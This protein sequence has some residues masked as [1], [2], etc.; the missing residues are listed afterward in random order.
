MIDRIGT[1]MTEAPERVF[2]W[3]VAIHM[4]VW[5]VVPWRLHPTIPMD[6]IEGFAWS[7]TWEL[8]YYKQPPV[9]TWVQGFW[10]DLTGGSSLAFYFLSQMFVAVAFWAV[11][12]LAR[13]ILPPARALL[14]VL[15]LEGIFY[16]NFESTDFNHNTAHLT[17]WPVIIL[18]FHRALM[19]RTMGTWVLL[20]VVTGLGL[21]SKYSIVFLFIP[22][23]V[24]LLIDRQ[25]RTVWRTPGPYVTATIMA[26]MAAPHF[27]WVIESGYQTFGYGYSRAR[28][29]TDWWVRLYY[30]VRFIFGQSLVLA[31]VAVMAA[32]LVW[33]RALPSLKPSQW[34]FDQR[35][36]AVL[37]AG[38]FLTYLATSAVLG[39]RI[40]T[41]WVMPIWSL[42]GIIVV[43]FLAAS[44]D[45]ARLRRFVRAWAGFFVLAVA[46]YT[47][48]LTVGPFVSG[49]PSRGYFPSA[50]LAQTVTSAWRKRFDTR[51][52]FVTGKTW[53]A[54]TLALAS[55]DRPL[56]FIEARPEISPA[57][58]MDAYRRAGSAFVW[59]ARKF[60]DAIP[61]G[62]AKQFPGLE[63]QTPLMLPWNRPGLIP[64]VS[65]GWPA[66]LPP[67]RVGWAV[68]PP[69]EN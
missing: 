3:F 69:G 7:R 22:M 14:A 62:W 46:V 2:R 37:G 38:P 56:V 10:F 9:P 59:D 60:G 21:L 45:V 25:S 51:L 31:P 53:M 65:W 64:P 8:G 49:K 36:V 44:P 18:V 42:T 50:A 11:W 55:E 33:R 26:G 48:M 17:L 54:A 23:L 32:I 13:D 16:F 47:V 41:I 4:I 40:R 1:M 6:T 34:T 28:E 5:T 35:F 19:R 66:P 63:L 61:F 12:R 15:L 52:A 29:F 57:I 68:L 39:F 30:P 20:G 67:L 58:D 43:L 24:F 27:W